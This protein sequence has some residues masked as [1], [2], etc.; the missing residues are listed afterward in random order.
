MMKP[1]GGSLKGLLLLA[2]LFGPLVGVELWSRGQLELL[3][4]LYSV[5]RMMTSI[6]SKL[7][8]LERAGCPE[9]LSFG[10]SISDH[11][12]LAD[13]A[14]GKELRFGDRRQ[15]ISRF[16]SFTLNGAK[17][18]HVYGVFRQIRAQGCVPDYIFMELSELILNSAQGPIAYRAV[19]D[20]GT[21]WNLPHDFGRSI[22]LDA[23]KLID[24]A[25]LMRLFIYRNRTII[26]A[27]FLEWVGLQPRSP[28]RPLALDGHI[29]PPAK[30]GLSGQNL[31]RE[32]EKHFRP[33]AKKKIEIR[34]DRF[35]LAALKLLIEEATRAGSK[36]VLHTPPMSEIFYELLVRRG[37]R[38]QFSRSRAEINAA[39]GADAHDVDWYWCYDE[40]F[41][42]EYFTDF[43]HMTGVGGSQY[44]TVL[45]EAVAAELAHEAWCAPRQ[46]R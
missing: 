20:A 42:N 2:L 25:T 44:T 38:D 1:P 22:G 7:M 15:P 13:A 11:A 26:Q 3:Y 29:Y 35:E 5:P 4:P 18:T 17:A 34:V 41:P 10:S 12:L 39:I 6:D 43:V 31:E 46:A 30:V 9:V 27:T 28:T 45:L 16:F 19:L 37:T 40:P 14:L 24:F 21:I 23:V 33:A 8:L 32:R 36:V